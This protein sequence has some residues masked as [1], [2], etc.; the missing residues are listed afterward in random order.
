LDFARSFK[1]GDNPIEQLNRAIAVL[2]L[3]P[4]QAHSK[5]DRVTLAQPVNRAIDP[6]LIV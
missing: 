5:L 3:T 6:Q 2:V 1:I 4:P